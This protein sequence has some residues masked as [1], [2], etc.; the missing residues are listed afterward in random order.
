MSYDRT[1]SFRR[2][3]TPAINAMTDEEIGAPTWTTEEP[4][5]DF[6]VDSFL[7]PFVLVR[8]KS[9]AVQGMLFFRHMPRIY[10]GF[11]EL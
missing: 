2:K 9:D 6:D 4:K 3:L 5:R 8:R 1:E 7:A 11:K 10:W